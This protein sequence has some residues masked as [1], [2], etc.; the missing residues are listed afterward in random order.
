ME[1]P[2]SITWTTSSWL[3]LQNSLS[4]R[5]LCQ[6]CSGSVKEWE[7]QSSQRSA[8]VH[9]FPGHCSG[10]LTA[11]AQIATREATGNFIP[12]QVMAWRTQ[13]H[14]V[15]A[16]ISHQEASFAAKMVPAGRLLLQRLIQLSIT[17]RRLHHHIHL[18]SPKPGKTYDGGTA[19]YSE[20]RIY[21]FIALEWND[22]ES[23]Q[24]LT[25]ASGSFGFGTYFYGAWFRGD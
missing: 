5:R 10:L 22:A 17:A 9:H 25:D 7:F 20:N 13:S 18:N 2:Y 3:A 11:A 14:Q 21:M 15:G 24:L 19:S 4:A 12:D 1:Q 16:P 23:I 8:R 6:P